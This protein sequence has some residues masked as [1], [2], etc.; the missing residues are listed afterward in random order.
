MNNL[1]ASVPIDM[2]NTLADPRAVNNWFNIHSIEH[3][4]AYKEMSRTG[5]WPQGFIPK[6]IVFPPNWSL[7][8][9]SRMASQYVE[10][11]ISRDYLGNIP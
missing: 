10:E 5:V 1:L 7:A 11:K 3:L 2:A 4:L 6:G 9:A 8:I